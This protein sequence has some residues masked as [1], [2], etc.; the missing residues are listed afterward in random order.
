MVY[1]A[2]VSR[3][4]AKNVEWGIKSDYFILVIVIAATTRDE[5]DAT[6]SRWPW[7]PPAVVPY[8]FYLEV[9]S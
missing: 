9:W 1:V 3:S 6:N 7:Y 4:L 2:G 5:T 8:G